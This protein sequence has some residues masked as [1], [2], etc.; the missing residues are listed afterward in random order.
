VTITPDETPRIG[1]PAERTIYQALRAQLQ[2]ND[3]DRTP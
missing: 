3:R 2:P 1:N